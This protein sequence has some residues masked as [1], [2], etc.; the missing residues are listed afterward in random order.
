M[1][2]Y[3]V[4]SGSY[5]EYRMEAVYSTREAAEQHVA[6]LNAPETCIVDNPTIEEYEVDEF[7]DH[8]A[9][10]FLLWHVRMGRDGSGFAH[11][12]SE[13][14]RLGQHSFDFPPRPQMEYVCWARD[15]QHAIKIA[16]EHRAQLIALGQWPEDR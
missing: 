9:Q 2:V 12:T 15:E 14:D 16:N 3:I 7:A 6:L 5:S 10:G 13:L 1:K 4:T 11:L 8:V